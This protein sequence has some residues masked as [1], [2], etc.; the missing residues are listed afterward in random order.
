[1]KHSLES[2]NQDKAATAGYVEVAA[3]PL[4]K[5]IHADS[6]FRA[7][8][9]NL[10]PGQA[11]VYHRHS[12][13]TLYLV[14]KGGRMSTRNFKGCKRGPMLFPRSFP[15]YKKLWLAL[16]NLFAGS[17][18]LPTGLSFFMPSRKHPSIHL[19]AAS[20]HNRETVCLMGIEL[21]QAATDRPVPVHEPL[22]GRVEYDEN[23]FKLFVCAIAAQ[24]CA[25]IALP[26]YQ[27]FMVSTK[28]LLEIRPETP[29]QGKNE[30]ERLPTGAYLS[31]CADAPLLVRNPG[32]TTSELTL[33]AVPANIYFSTSI[34]CPSSASPIGQTG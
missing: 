13:D 6:Y 14:I 3:E 17:A 33:L 5:E 28:G 19:A 10:D 31:I 25:R 16:Q 9:A 15:L 7:Y 24:A 26:G 11:T 8:L 12:Q 2:K 32:N 22:P 27:L 29:P 4:H 30:P 34:P 20:P 23:S 18:Y 21:R 1:M